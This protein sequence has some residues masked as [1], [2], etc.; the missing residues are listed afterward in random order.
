M[1]LP[2]QINYTT[3]HQPLLASEHYTGHIE[4]KLGAGDVKLAARVLQGAFYE[5][6]ASLHAAHRLPLVGAALVGKVGGAC[7]KAA[8]EG[9]GRSERE[10]A[11]GKRWREGGGG[12]ACQSATSK[13]Q[14][15]KIGAGAGLLLA[16]QACFCRVPAPG[17]SRG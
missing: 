11:E 14:A 2:P 8:G 15:V 10:R 1:L 9:D 7:R 12:R 13:M 4:A 16:A 6:E 17:L 5:A 3:Q